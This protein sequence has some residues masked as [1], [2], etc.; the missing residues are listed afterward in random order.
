MA[1]FAASVAQLMA[2]VDELNAL[3][4][5]PVPDGDTGSNMLA[6]VRAA[7]AEAQAVPAEDRSV[8]RIAEAI[9]FGALMGARGNSG[10]ILSQIFRGM[11][12]GLALRRRFDGRDLADGLRRG[13]DAAY[14]AVTKPV[15]G[16]ILTAVSD[17]AEAANV[18][19]ERRQDLEWV[20]TAAVDGAARAVARTPS[21]L[22]I[23]REAGVVD[24]GAQGLYLVLQGA[25]LHV[26]GRSPVVHHAGPVAS[27]VRV[28]TP[29][30]DTG[31]DGSF[32]YE[33]MYLLQAGREPLDLAAI[34]S[35]LESI[36]QSV[37]VAGDARAVKIHVHNERPD[38]VIAYGLSLGSL[39]RVSIENLDDQ[40]RDVGEARARAFTGVLVSAES[41]RG[42]AV[43]V[44]G[45][46]K[47]DR[48]SAG[49][50]AAPASSVVA[51][52][53]GEGLVRI[54]ESFGVERIVSERGKSTNASTGQLLDAIR[55]V[56]SHDV[57]ILP[58]DRNVLLAAEQAGSL[59][60]AKTVVVVPT[61]NA[62][63]GFA[64]LLALD[65]A[66]GA[67]ANREPMLRA[68]RAIQTILVTAAARDARVGSQEVRKGQT[69]ALDAD[70]GLF[71]VHPDRL[72]AAMDAVARLHPGFELLTL[73]HGEG[74]D[75]EEATA[76][77]ELIRAAHPSAEVEVEHGGQPH[78]SYLIAAE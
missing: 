55:A 49:G 3:N 74:A 2:N 23:L 52:T 47:A 65:P 48:T 41:R 42:G 78:Y 12:E 70:D 60:T 45:R 14:A 27:E 13:R 62:A 30:A 43:A 68:A 59:A 63:E 25:L 73:Y 15:E 4:V 72:T 5:Y 36:G 38:G 21:L 19:A 31:A 9:S 10:V 26:D 44:D 69:I 1:A 61:R 50:V 37:L 8:Q 24:A 16:T 77:A 76:L 66:L 34:R 67:A 53:A 56:A 75:A 33:T 64:A 71:A 46:P 58:N 54:F 29:D 18:A 11:S 51:V 22:P 28:S 39:S 17:A 57:L 40:A 6:T 20:L 7:L 35:Y 32:G